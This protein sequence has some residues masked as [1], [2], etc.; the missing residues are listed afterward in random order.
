MNPTQLGPY[1]IRSRLGRGGMGEVY[2]AVDSG[3]GQTVAVKILRSHLVDDASIRQRF[4]SEIEALKNLRHPGIVRMIAFGEQDNDPY[5][6]MEFVRGKSL[7]QLLRAGR[8]FSWRQ[9]VAVAGEVGQLATGRDALASSEEAPGKNVSSSSR[10]PR[11]LPASETPV[12]HSRP[13]M[14]AERASGATTHP[15]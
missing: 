8:R 4:T 7:E 13:D 1:V 12:S 9:A 15:L 10:V 14:P 2:E 11:G 5:F 6:A 3:T